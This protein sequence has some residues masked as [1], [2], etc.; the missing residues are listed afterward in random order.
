MRMSLGTSRRLLLLSKVHFGGRSCCWERRRPSLI[1]SMYA[2]Q[3]CLENDSSL[4][5][6]EEREAWLAILIW[7][8]EEGDLHKCEKEIRVVFIQRIPY[9][10]PNQISKT[11][12]VKG[13]ICRQSQA[14]SQKLTNDKWELLISLTISYFLTRDNYWGH[15]RSTPTTVRCS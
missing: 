6:G 1:L 14:Y 13:S 2:R 15:V 5:G 9:L 8:E 7:K 10:C 3:N 4:F 11:C 12:Y